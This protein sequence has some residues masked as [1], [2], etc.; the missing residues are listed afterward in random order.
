MIKKKK[1]LFLLLKI[2]SLPSFYFAGTV[3][4]CFFKVYFMLKSKNCTDSS[5]D[6]L[7]LYGGQYPVGITVTL[8]DDANW[9]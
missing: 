3:F 6:Q 9:A 7:C 4:Q 1:I 5:C 8:F 2:K